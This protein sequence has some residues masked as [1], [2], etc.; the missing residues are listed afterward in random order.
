MN[1]GNHPEGV[2]PEGTPAAVLGEGSVAQRLSC[3]AS[4]LRRGLRDL[5]G[6]SEDVALL[7]SLVKHMNREEE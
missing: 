1:T 6:C 2:C 7:L 4:R 5:A 3:E